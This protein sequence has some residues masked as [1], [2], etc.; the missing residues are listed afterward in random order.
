MIQS[1]E[2]GD[3]SADMTV[4]VDECDHKFSVSPDGDTGVVSYEETLIGRGT[5]VVSDPNESVWKQLMQSDHMT[6]YLESQ[7][8]QDV[9]R[10]R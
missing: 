10:D 6:A 8:L 1:T 7:D 2:R 4:T 3:G 9:Q 5:V